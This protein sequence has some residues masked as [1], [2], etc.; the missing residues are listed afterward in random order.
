MEFCHQPAPDEE[1]CAPPLMVLDSL[2]VN[3]EHSAMRDLKGKCDKRMHKH[4]RHSGG[5]GVADMLL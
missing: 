3:V 5:V 2:P 1:K 4:I